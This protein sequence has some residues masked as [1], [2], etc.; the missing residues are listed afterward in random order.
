[1]NSLIHH[2]LL[3]QFAGVT[4]TWRAAAVTVGGKQHI[5][6]TTGQGGSSPRQVPGLLDPD[7]HAGQGGHA[8]YIFALPDRL[9]SK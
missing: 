6:V 2:R 7:V 4:L 3:R 8:L 9:V 1:V 5:A